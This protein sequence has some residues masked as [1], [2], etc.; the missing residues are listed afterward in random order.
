MGREMTK[1]P[2][3]ILCL[4][5]FFGLTSASVEIAYRRDD[6]HFHIIKYVCLKYL[7]F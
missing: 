6:S 4:F 3:S 7:Y 5:F 2:V 1:N